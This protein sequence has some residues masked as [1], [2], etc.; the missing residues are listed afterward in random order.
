METPRF[1]DFLMLPTSLS[2]I[3][4]AGHDPRFRC[5][6]NK[7]TVK[8]QAVKFVPKSCDDRNATWCTDGEQANRSLL[9]FS[10]CHRIARS[11]GRDLADV[12]D[13]ADVYISA[14]GTL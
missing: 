9:I 3:S 11:K 10:A 13:H 14:G 7:I 5:Q 8:R 12:V 1:R 6:E 2:K 4:Y